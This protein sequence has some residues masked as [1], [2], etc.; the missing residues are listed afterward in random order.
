MITYRPAAYKPPSYRPAP[1]RKLGQEAP[2]G[3]QIKT[4]GVGLGLVSVTLSGAAAWVG[5]HTGMKEQGILSIAGWLVG[6]T[7]AILGGTSFFGTMGLLLTPS[8]EIERKMKEEELRQQQEAPPTPAP[9][10]P[11]QFEITE[12]PMPLEVV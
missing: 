8:E 12:T 5:I 2:T 4:A 6:V 1:P 11:G 7:G 10:R 9:L 3:A